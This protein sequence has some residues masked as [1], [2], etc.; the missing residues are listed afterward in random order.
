M[1]LSEVMAAF[2]QIG[3]WKEEEIPDKRKHSYY[4]VKMAIQYVLNLPDGFDR[5]VVALGDRGEKKLEQSELAKLMSIIQSSSYIEV[6]GGYPY[7]RGPVFT[8]LAGKIKEAFSEAIDEAS[9]GLSETRDRVGAAGRF[10][11]YYVAPGKPAGNPSHNGNPP[12]RPFGRA[13]SPFG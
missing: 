1:K 8:A 5:G 3:D 9:A 4:T 6:M 2:S 7:S 11:L 13:R 10:Q 12:A